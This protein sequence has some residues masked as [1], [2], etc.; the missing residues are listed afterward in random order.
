MYRAYFDASGNPDEHASVVVAGCVASVD[1]WERMEP[2]WNRILEEEG[3]AE[4][5]GY[6]A[7]HMRD[8]TA[9]K[10]AFAGWT[11]KQKATLLTRLGTLMRVRVAFLVG[12]G[13]PISVHE[14]SQFAL[15]GCSGWAPH[16]ATYCATV[17]VEEVGGWC[18]RNNVDG[19]VMTYIFEDGDRNRDELGVL[20]DD[21]ANNERKA[22]DFR[23]AGWSFGSKRLVGLQAADW[24][25]YETFLWGQREILPLYGEAKKS[26]YPRRR[27]LEALGRIE[28]RISY[29]A[30]VEEFL[31]HF[32][33]RFDVLMKDRFRS[34]S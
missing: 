1:Q 29:M 4:T 10:R 34:V 7:L 22:K 33:Q 31:T 30:G 16:P 11:A 25:A 26:A 21:T 15:L 24:I 2:D 27:A 23:Y 20:M 28:N 8:L 3:V 19:S 17:C 14:A 9:S 13:M 32:R 18:V 5:D 6:R 12:N